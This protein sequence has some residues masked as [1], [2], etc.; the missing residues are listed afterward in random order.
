VADRLRPMT[1]R[2]LEFQIEEIEA[3]ELGSVAAP[4]LV[5]VGENDEA[6]FR[7]IAE[8][9]V[10]ELPDA[11]LVVIPSDARARE[12]FPGAESQALGVP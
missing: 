1:R 10:R 2:S 7:A 12:A 4:A 11:E 9:L 8:R 5:G 6:D 3:V